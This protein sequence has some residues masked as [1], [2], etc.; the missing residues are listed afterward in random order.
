MLVPFNML[1]F[2]L[3]KLT[4]LDLPECYPTV[5]FFEG[6]FAAGDGN[7]SFYAP[8]GIWRGEPV[9]HAHT[10][11]PEVFIGR[12]FDIELESEGVRLSYTA[13]SV[14]IPVTCD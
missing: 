3:E 11:G 1:W 13:N 9:A 14:L 6:W 2:S 4:P 7:V 8:S 10:T 12:K 5:V